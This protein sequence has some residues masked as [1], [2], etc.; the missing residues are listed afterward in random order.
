V[1]DPLKAT[2]TA[3]T[4]PAFQDAIYGGSGLV[5]DGLIITS[6]VCPT[7]EKVLGMENGTV[8]LT[9]AFIVAVTGK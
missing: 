2:Q 3:P 7:L 5:Q 9:N 8:K 1:R 6:G 4:F